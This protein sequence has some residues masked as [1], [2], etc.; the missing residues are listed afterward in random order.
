M[1]LSTPGYFAVMC[2][3]R[4]RLSHPHHDGALLPWLRGA[5]IGRRFQGVTNVTPPYSRERGCDP[6]IPSSLLIVVFPPEQ[7]APQAALRKP[8]PTSDDAQIVAG[9]T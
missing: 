2:S 1:T 3:L 5:D 7:I 8:I 9:S 4:I 6:R